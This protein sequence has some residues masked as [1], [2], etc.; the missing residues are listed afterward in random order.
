MNSKRKNTKQN[1]KPSGQ[2][3]NIL[4]F[5]TEKAVIKIHDR[6]IPLVKQKT[7]R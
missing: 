2:N 5:Y 7:N 4:S 3:S 6:L 1:K